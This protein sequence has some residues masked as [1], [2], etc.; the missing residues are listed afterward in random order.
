MADAAP[1]NPVTQGADSLIQFA[2]M[3]VAANMVIAELDTEVP[4]LA[5]PVLHEISDEAIYFI[6]QRLSTKLQGF[7]N[8]EI[9]DVQT[10]GEESTYEA[11]EGALR[12][13]ELSG[14]PVAL[15]KASSD[16]DAALKSLVTF[17][18]PVASS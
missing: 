10:D 14:D 9:I 6:A 3:K 15:Q 17:D 1:V 16:F 12:K 2:I 8:Y 18:N 5:A 11:A 4:L 7:A 13:A